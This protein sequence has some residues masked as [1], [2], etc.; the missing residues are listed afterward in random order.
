MYIYLIDNA[1]AL[2]GPVELPVIPGLGT[3]L[4][5]NAVELAELLS[6]P[7]EGHAWALIDDQAQQLVD[8]RGTVYR[9]DTGA[10]E[11]WGLL[12]DLPAGLTLK[13]WPG[14]FYVWGGGD[15][16]L[17]EVAQLNDKAADALV[18]RDSRLREATL[19]IAP[20][21]DAVD[22]GEATSQEEA[23]LVL[24]K[25][26]RVA[27]NRIQDQPGYPNEITWPAPPA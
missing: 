3:Q 8:H 1:G 6:E 10:A 17:D 20:L 7:S 15:W 5:S 4:P 9:T 21:Q 2:T 23:L 13:P 14:E 18:E 19:R 27:L 16:V 22:L 24:W 11:A 26:Y 25:K 12:G